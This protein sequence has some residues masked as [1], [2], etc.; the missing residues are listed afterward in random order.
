[1]AEILREGAALV[2]RRVETPAEDPFADLMG[3]V[4]MRTGVAGKRAWIIRNAE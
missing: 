3:T 2:V 1:M 4:T